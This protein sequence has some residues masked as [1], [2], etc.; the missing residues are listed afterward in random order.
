MKET[1]RCPYCGEEIMAKA[2]KCR[3]CGEWLE[4]PVAATQATGLE[5][6][7]PAEEADDSEQ[8]LLPGSAMLTTVLLLLAVVSECLLLVHA[9][10][11]TTIIDDTHAFGLGKWKT[12][13]SIF[14]AMAKV[15]ETLCS[16]VNIIAMLGLLILFL[17]GMKRLPHPFTSLTGCF[18]GLSAFLW[19][20]SF[21]MDVA[22]SGDPSISEGA[23]IGLYVFIFSVVVAASVLQIVLGSKLMLNYTGNI[24]LVGLLFVI[25]GG[26]DFISVLIYALSDNPFGLMLIITSCLNTG[27]Y[28]LL[29]FKLGDLLGMHSGIKDELMYVFGLFIAGVL[30]YGINAY[31]KYGSQDGEEYGQEYGSASDEDG[32]PTGT[33]TASPEN[34]EFVAESASADAIY[35][36]DKENSILYKKPSGS[37][38]IFSINIGEILAEECF[39]YGIEDYAVLNN[40]IFFI[41]DSG[42]TGAGA[43]YNAYYFDMANETW[44]YIKFARMMSFDSSKTHIKAS[45]RTL[46]KAGASEAEN[47]YDYED[48]TINLADF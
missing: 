21:V 47:E 35:F 22:A 43:G 10:W 11:M 14:K 16:V 38:E 36:L 41:S 7:T 30:I 5:P 26:F 9:D 45:V 42:A 40:K 39:I 12:I 17:K 20:L 34:S 28:I 27:L 31:Q 33:S 18:I 24:W 8:A 19:V 15:P 32:A 29:Y 1:K 2:K 23:A 46:V 13:D 37:S 44:Y 3:H 4:Q 6:E 48:Q 25:I